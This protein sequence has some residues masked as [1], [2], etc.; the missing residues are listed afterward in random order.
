MAS[1]ICFH[2]SMLSF[3]ARHR[4]VDAIA[5]LLTCA[6]ES[7]LS[8]TTPGPRF[9]AKSTGVEATGGGRGGGVVEG[10]SREMRERERSVMPS[11]ASAS[12][13]CKRRRA[14]AASTCC[15]NTVTCV[16]TCVCRASSARRG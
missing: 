11:A 16:E 14:V 4:T 13:R 6:V 8:A 1:R 12:A 2:D 10:R 9:G 5:S 7:V 15:S 3:T